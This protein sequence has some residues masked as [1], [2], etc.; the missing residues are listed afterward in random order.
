MKV[1]VVLESYCLDPWEIVCI[2][3]TRKK[4][5]DKIKYISENEGCD[6]IYYSYI[7]KEMEVE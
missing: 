2:F 5:E 4:A 3:D 6:N 7:I 1:Y